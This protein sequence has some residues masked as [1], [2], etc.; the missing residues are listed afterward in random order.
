MPQYRTIAEFE[1]TA[2]PTKAE[3]DLIT[4]CK[5]GEHCILGDG[6]RPET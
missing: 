6:T 3:L 1:A 5:A 4:A 2:N